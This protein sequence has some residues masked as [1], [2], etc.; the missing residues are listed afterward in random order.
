[1]WPHTKR[2]NAISRNNLHTFMAT[3]SEDKK[4][5]VYLLPK[6]ELVRTVSL[7]SS[8]WDIILYENLV[9]TSDDKIVQL[10]TIER[11][12]SDEMLPKDQMNQSQT[13]I[14]KNI[15]NAFLE[16]AK[17]EW[18]LNLVFSIKVHQT[19]LEE[20]TQNIVNDPKTRNTNRN[21]II[22]MC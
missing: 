13:A 15:L 17:Y 14:Y 11:T 16:T 18:K 12:I 7:R 8:I 5:N 6:I 22:A 20:N 1:M 10:Y 2:I 3:C 9:I 19:S 4:F 21:R